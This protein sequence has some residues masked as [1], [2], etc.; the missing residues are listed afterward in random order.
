MQVGTSLLRNIGGDPAAFIPLLKEF[1]VAGNKNPE[2][3]SVIQSIGH[4]QG[5]L[6]RPEFDILYST[7]QSGTSEQRYWVVNEIAFF[8][9][10]RSRRVRHALIEVL[11]NRTA[12]AEVRGWA[13]ERLHL[14]ISQETIRS[15]IRAVEDPS[16]EVRLWAV[17]T[18][19]SAAS[20]YGVPHP[21]YRDVVTNCAGASAR[22]RCC[23]A[24]VVVRAP[25]S[26]GSSTTRSQRP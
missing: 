6:T 2:L 25:R 26:P 1:I 12:P 21:L 18:L 24:R 9:S 19:G 11:E 16:P 22:G 4:G 17:C 20:S 23:C 13:A 10:H 5:H 3:C 7:L 14:H 15:C 8:T